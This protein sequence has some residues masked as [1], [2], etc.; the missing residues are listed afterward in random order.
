MSYNCKL[1]NYYTNS[2]YHYKRHLNTKKHNKNITIYEEENDLGENE[3]P[4]TP[5]DSPGLPWT[6][7]PQKSRKKLKYVCKYCNN[8]FTRSSNLT[9]HM[10]YVCSEKEVYLQNE[11]I[12]ELIKTI[13][14][15]DKGNTNHGTINNYSMS[16]SNNSQNNLNLNNFGEENLDMITDKFLKKSIEYPFAGLT[17]MIE[18]IHFNEKFPENKNV[19]MLN[20]KGNK[21]QIVDKGK[22]KY[23]DK[24]ETFRRLVDN[25]NSSMEEFYEDNKVIFSKI[26]KKRYEDFRENLNEDDKR[27]WDKIYKSL[28]LIF[29]NSM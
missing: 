24:G 11:K 16:N 23:V 7:N 25:K 19:R 14:E 10:K 17:K 28:E 29:W 13:K 20:K 6:P 9:K 26:N 8:E 3:L 22:W 12:D 21:L 27:Y 4:W 15:K 1:C 18:K 5:L 2:I